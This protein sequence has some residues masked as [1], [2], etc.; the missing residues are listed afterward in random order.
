MSRIYHNVFINWDAQLSDYCDI[1]T[2]TIEGYG[3]ST[4]DAIEGVNHILS[5]VFFARN[6]TKEPSPCHLLSYS[7]EIHVTKKKIYQITVK[8]SIIVVIVMRYIQSNHGLPE[9]ISGQLQGLCF[10][11]FLLFTIHLIS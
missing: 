1:I 4:T 2:Q 3:W 11:S 10:G 7:E 5:F 6:L 8:E 9:K